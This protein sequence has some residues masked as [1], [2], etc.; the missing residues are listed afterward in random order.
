MIFIALSYPSIRVLCRVPKS[1]ISCVFTP[2]HIIYN[3]LRDKVHVELVD[4][5]VTSKNPAIRLFQYIF[6]RRSE[7]KHLAE[8]ILDQAHARKDFEI[9]FTCHAMDYL[10]VPAIFRLARRKEVRITLIWENPNTSINDIRRVGGPLIA[11]KNVFFSYVCLTTIYHGRSDPTVRSFPVVDISIHDIT[12]SLDFLRKYKILGAWRSA[13]DSKPTFDKRQRFILLWGYSESSLSFYLDYRRLRALTSKLVEVGVFLKPHP[14][15]DLTHLVESF[16]NAQILDRFTPIEFYD[17]PDTFFLVTHSTAELSPT[18]VISIGK[19]V[20][21]DDDLL[22]L[23]RS[24]GWMIAESD[25]E[26]LGYIKKISTPAC[27]TSS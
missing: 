6:F 22:M 18:R 25:E 26:L 2:S 23:H 19:L 20:H 4:T 15:G 14:F 5:R 17:S 21:L 10:T 13:F 1:S 24:N 16:P 9:C 27:V 3:L 12:I 7:V 11:L 8:T